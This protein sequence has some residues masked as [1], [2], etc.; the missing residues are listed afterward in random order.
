MARTMF[1]T[2]TALA[3]FLS[4]PVL[5][6]SSAEEIVQGE[7]PDYVTC[8][9]SEECLTVKG[10]C[11]EWRVVNRGNEKKLTDAISYLSMA[12]NCKEYVP[13][14]SKPSPACSVD[15]ICQLAQ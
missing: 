6:A 8:K 1:Y 11:G 4:L 14:R 12:T 15:G 13:Y 9:K 5:A 3:V 2:L 7:H 10:L